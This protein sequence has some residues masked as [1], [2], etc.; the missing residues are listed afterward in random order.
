MVCI[1]QIVLICVGVATKVE[2]LKNALAEAEG[3][4]VQ[5]Q[6]ARKKLKARV[7]EVQKELQDAV[8]KCEALERDASVQETELAKARQSM[9][10]ARNEAQGTLQATHE[11]RKI[12]AGKAFSMQSKCVK[13]KYLLLTRIRSSPGAFAD[14]SCSVSDAA[15]FFWAE[16][17]SSTE[18]LFWSQYLAPKHP[19]P[20]SD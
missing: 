16:E 12:A 8:K 1:D 3:K 7:D 11:A 10:T 15:E 5:Q 2:A 19:V 20:F 18:K 9:E 4:A 14:L 6:V 13:R 17:G